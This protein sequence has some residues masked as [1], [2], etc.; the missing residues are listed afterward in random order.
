[1][2]ILLVW[3]NK[4]GFGFKPIGQA[5]L[6]ALLK[7]EGH[8]V[9][10]FDTTFMDLGYEGISQIRTKLKI[11][12]PVD[13]SSHDVTKKPVEMGR[14]LNVVLEEF[15]P[16]LVGLS[17]LSD[18]IRIA[19][20]ISTIV[21]Q[22]DKQVP[23]VWGN[24][25]PTLA[26]DDILK[27]KDVDYVCIG[28]GIRFLVEFAE[29]LESGQDPRT[30]KNVAFRGADGETVRSNLAGLH[31]DL[32]SLPMLDWSVFDYRHFLKPFDGEVRV[33]GD[34]MIQWG[35][36]NDCTYCINH[37]Y[38]KLYGSE[39]G[40]FIRQYTIDRIINELQYLVKKWG[41]RLFQVS[42]RR[43]LP[44]ADFV[45]SRA[46]R[47]VSTPRGHSLHGDGKRPQRNP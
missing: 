20:R 21:K 8:E 44:K 15:N 1:M 35:C 31:Q 12:K 19:E 45:F 4:G 41:S 22:W 47:E 18:E 6:A 40:R 30:L 38:R 26:P 25:A 10:L 34:H 37:A 14:E 27:H 13:F 17:V 33:G 2:R 29:C 24:K 36:V 7:Q 46:G 11:F 23:V 43:F 5:L 28:E 16:N 42:R 32:D 39:S 9:E 3:P